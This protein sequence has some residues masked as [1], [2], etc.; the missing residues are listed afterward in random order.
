MFLEK[1]TR[2]ITPASS[3]KPTLQLEIRKSGTHQLMSKHSHLIIPVTLCR[4]WS[5][6]T[7]TTAFTIH[8]M[9]VTKEQFTR[10]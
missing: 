6:V 3:V 4:L 8:R 10:H 7:H 2:N 1:E 5:T 9:Q